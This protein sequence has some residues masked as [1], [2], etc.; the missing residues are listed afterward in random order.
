MKNKNNILL[1]LAALMSF[2]SFAQEGN[3]SRNGTTPIGIELVSFDPMTVR[4]LSMISNS[5]DGKNIETF[6]ESVLGSPYIYDAMLPAKVNN[7]KDIVSARYDAYKDLV[8]VQISKTKNFY[9]EKRIGNKIKFSKTNDEYRVF[10]DEKERA[11]FFKV[12]KATD[13]FSLLKKQEIKLTGGEKPKNTYDEYKA[14]AFKRAKDKL[15]LSLDN[16]NA[17]KV[18]TSK[19]KFYKLFAGNSSKIKEFVKKNKLSIKNEKDLLK[20]LEYYAS[21]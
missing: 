18:P 3:I 1:I 4:N 20:A 14:P 2:S 6:Y 5:V 9:L 7:F 13:K 11:S 8:T 12:M 17:M 10:Y 19:K 21:L 16:S 15:Y